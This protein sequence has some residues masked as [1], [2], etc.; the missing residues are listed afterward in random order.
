[1]DKWKQLPALI[2]DHSLRLAGYINAMVALVAA[3]VSA[4][5]SIESTEHKITET[6]QLLH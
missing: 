5:S 1:M 4:K 3:L 2:H 6:K